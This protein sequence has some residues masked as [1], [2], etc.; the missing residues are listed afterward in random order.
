MNVELN[1]AAAYYLALEGASN[2]LISIK[3]S[4]NFKIFHMPNTA[5]YYFIQL[6]YFIF[7]KIS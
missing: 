2:P 3:I 5:S 6:Y 7:H 1:D 4:Q